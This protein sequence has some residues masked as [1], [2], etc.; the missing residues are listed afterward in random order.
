MREALKAAQEALEHDDVPIGAVIVH[1]KK[2]IARA[3]NQVELLKD[4]TAHAEMIAI[5][6][7]AAVLSRE[8]LEKTI[9]YSTVEPCVMCAGAMVLAR[10]KELFYAAADPK[11]GGCGSVFDIVNDVRL[12]HQVKVV[13]GLGRDEAQALL[14]SFFQRL[15][16]K[17]NKDNIA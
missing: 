11:A 2:I 17:R 3:H 4:P 1:E 12:N 7:A 9:L 13:H 8:R 15:R 14:Q 5:T 10:I 6:Q 16:K